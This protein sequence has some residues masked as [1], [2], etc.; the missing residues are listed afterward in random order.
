MIEETKLFSP[1]PKLESESAPDEIGQGESTESK[2]ESAVVKLVNYVHNCIEEDQNFSMVYFD[3]SD[4]N[5]VRKAQDE[6]V[7]FHTQQ[8]PSHRLADFHHRLAVLTLE[9]AEREGGAG[10]DEVEL[11]VASAI[12]A[13]RV[14]LK[15]LKRAIE[16]E[17]NAL[18]DES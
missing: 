7:T 9:M 4:Y 8:D 13:L 16:M 14:A 17:K 3:R 6:L 12:L 15:R 11:E 10:G 1:E 2:T 18:G 5:L